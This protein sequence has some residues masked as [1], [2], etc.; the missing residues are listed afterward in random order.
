M[1]EELAKTLGVP[2]HVFRGSEPSRQSLSEE[3][4]AREETRIARMRKAVSERVMQ[5]MLEHAFPEM[6]WET[7]F[8]MSP[9]IKLQV[10]RK[11]AGLKITF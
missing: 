10:R 5:P 11:D 4:F 8:I 2:E 9:R 7:A 6:F 1:I 3:W